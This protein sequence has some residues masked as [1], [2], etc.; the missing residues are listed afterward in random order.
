MVFTVLLLI[1]LLLIFVLLFLV[2]LFVLILLDR[3]YPASL[4]ALLDTVVIA[5]S[6]VVTLQ[7]GG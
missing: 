1:I 4:L 6:V 3:R 7:A 5:A 2:L